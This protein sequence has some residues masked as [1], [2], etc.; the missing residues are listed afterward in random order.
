M[1]L[2]ISISLFGNRLPPGVVLGAAIVFGSAAVWAWDG[3]RQKR[4]GATGAGGKERDPKSVDG[5]RPA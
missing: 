4:P 1:S 2:F 3:Q 5:K